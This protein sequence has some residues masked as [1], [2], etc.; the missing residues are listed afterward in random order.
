MTASGGV[1]HLMA[2][3]NDAAAVKWL[4]E[5]GV[6][7]NARWSHWDA[8]VTPLHL[9]ILAGHADI[10]RLLL[11]AGADP[12]IRDSRHRRRRARLGRVLRTEGH[13]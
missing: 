10:A 9:A 5:H 7:P 11:E 1:L 8:D 3:R 4:L 12:H 6:N 2:K 13:R